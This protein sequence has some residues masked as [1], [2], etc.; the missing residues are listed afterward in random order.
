MGDYSLAIET[1]SQAGSIALGCGEDLVATADVPQHRRHNLELMPTIARLCDAHGIGPADLAEVYVSIGPGS[2]T[3]LRIGIAT[4]KMLALTRGVRVVAV[5]TLDVLVCRAAAA[6]SPV[7][8]CLNLKHD[9]AWSAVYAWDGGHW[10][11]AVEPALRTLAQV[12]ALAPRT[13]L[14]HTTVPHSDALWQL[15]RAAA[16]CGRYTDP[17]HLSPLYAREPEA[18]ALWEAL[19]GGAAKSL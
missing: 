9:T 17:M 11:Q 19:Q 15:G 14:D 16:K 7:A 4:A 5:P 10:R 18:V 13:I 12:Q 3:G 2:F 8:A 1:S 6:D